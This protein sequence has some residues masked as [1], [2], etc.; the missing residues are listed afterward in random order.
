M[1]NRNDLKSMLDELETRVTGQLR[2]GADV[3]AFWPVFATESNRV[4]E[5]AGPDD[6]DWVSSQIDDMLQRHGVPVPEA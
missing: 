3:N 4:L 1:T 2:D 5:A 6:F